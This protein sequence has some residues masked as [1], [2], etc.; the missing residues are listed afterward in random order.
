MQA[1]QPDTQPDY[2]GL[3]EVSQA[4]LAVMD[5]AM[6]ANLIIRASG[7]K[8]NV[9]KATLTSLEIEGYVSHSDTGEYIR[10]K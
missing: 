1:Q 9:V 3:D 6:N 7:L 8:A 10:T 4:V 5:G 2:S